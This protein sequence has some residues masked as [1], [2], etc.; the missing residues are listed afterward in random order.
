MKRFIF[1]IVIMCLFVGFA[2][3][4]EVPTMQVDTAPTPTPVPVFSSDITFVGTYTNNDEIIAHALIEPIGAESSEPLPL[5][6]WLHGSGEV[7]SDENWF[8]TKSLPSVFSNW[9]LEGFN[10]YVVC[11]HL[12]GRFGYSHW[13]AGYCEDNL[14]SL[15]ASLCE[16]YNI[17]PNRIYIGGASLGGIG[18][19][20]MAVKM[21]DIFSKCVVFNGYPTASIDINSIAIPT[22]GY[23]GSYFFGEDN[24]SV[25][26]MTTQL[27]KVIG[28]ENI[29][30]LDCSHSD[31][32]RAAFN[33]DEDG[34]NH[35][36][37]IEWL[38]EN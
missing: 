32:P 29:Y 37:I 15:I 9:E 34:N 23:V 17:D 28:E 22:R 24:H 36:D 2:V 18:A 26:Y 19:Q 38:F 3:F 27:A 13:A 1:Y 33:L 14:R 35:S 10:A 8:M 7:W 12:S 25:L 31:L 20:H 30:Q 5:L 16:E 21:S 4:C 6:V 11:P